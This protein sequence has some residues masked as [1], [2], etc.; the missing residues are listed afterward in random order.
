MRATMSNDKVRRAD[1]RVTHRLS[2]DDITGWLA[3]VASV[4][5]D[6]DDL[7]ERLTK[8]AADRL[9]RDALVIRGSD[10]LMDW[11]DDVADVETYLEWAREQANRIYGRSFGQT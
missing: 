5:Y 11:A 9:L 4:Q 10:G 3:C 8:S 2:L 6:P 7:P 1:F